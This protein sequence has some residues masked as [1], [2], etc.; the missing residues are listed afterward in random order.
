M[1]DTDPAMELAPEAVSDAGLEI[2]KNHLREAY[3]RIGRAA[4][5]SDGV[6]LRDFGATEGHPSFK[7]AGA[8][9]HIRQTIEDIE[10]EQRRREGGE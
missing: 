3:D 7:M 9:A 1:S 4:D 6:D 10:R 5:R 8:A 2:M